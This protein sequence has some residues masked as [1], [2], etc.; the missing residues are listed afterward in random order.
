LGNQF[1]GKEMSEIIQKY[2][3]SDFKKPPK[4]IKKPAKKII[5]EWP[6]FP[7]K[8]VKPNA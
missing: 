2:K 4:K 6:W 3:A 8:E 5:F 7:P 1:E